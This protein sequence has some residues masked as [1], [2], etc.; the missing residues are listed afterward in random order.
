MKIEE[1]TCIA[2]KNDGTLLIKANVD[3]AEESH[4]YAFY[5]YKGSQTLYKSPYDKKSFIMH[6]VDEFGKYQIKAFVRNADGT[7]KDSMV[8]PY[9]VNKSN[10][11]E[12][13]VDEIVE[14]LP[15]IK[16]TAQN[17]SNNAVYAFAEGELTENMQYAWYV[18]NMTVK[19]PVYKGKYSSEPSIS[20]MVKEHG[21]YYAKLFI[22]DGTKK[23]TYKSEVVTF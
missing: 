5:I 8:L 3:K 20:Y 10:A 19:E 15:K 11:R 1:I 9:V 18:Y 6:K 2:V 22:K 23:Y 21:T 7:E 14:V 12:L 4:R 17:I 13:V 16:L